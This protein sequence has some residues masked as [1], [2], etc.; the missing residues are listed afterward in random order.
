VKPGS[1]QALY[2]LAAL[3]AAQLAGVEGCDISL[4]FTPKAEALDV[5][6]FRETETATP[7]LGSLVTQLR[8]TDLGPNV[9]LHI[10]DDDTVKLTD[11]FAPVP[12]D[13][14]LPAPPSLFI[15]DAKNGALLASRSLTAN[16]SVASIVASMKEHSP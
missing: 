6:I 9:R 8:N 4:P 16:E 5:L 12:L 14:L 1:K 10:L 3:V 13:H 2:L 11:Y 15:V 7:E